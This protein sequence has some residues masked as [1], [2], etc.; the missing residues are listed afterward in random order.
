MVSCLNITC[1]RGDRTIFYRLGFSLLPGSLLQLTGGNGAGKTSLLRIMAGLLPA[2]GQILFRNEQ[3]IHYLAHQNA[4]K[5]ELSVLENLRF[6][7]K[8]SGEEILLTPAMR[9]WG[10]E[11]LADMRVG[12]LSAGWQRRTAL[13]RLMVSPAAVWLLDEP[14]QNLD[15]KGKALLAG[16]ISAQCN[17]GGIVVMA[18]HEMDLVKPALQ[19]AMEDFAHG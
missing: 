13:A 16:M 4:L 18:T 7:A 15:S 1:Q 10:L 8:L 6:W 14:T 3:G 2:E 5:P 9:Y 11:A 17:G 19:L 12:R